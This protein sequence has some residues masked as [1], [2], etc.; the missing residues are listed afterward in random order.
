MTSL[1]GNSD[2]LTDGHQDLKLHCGKLERGV[3]MFMDHLADIQEHTDHI[4]N[5][6]E[7]IC[8]C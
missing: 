3:Q 6:T 8:A 2:N 4:S 5:L 7:V 1:S